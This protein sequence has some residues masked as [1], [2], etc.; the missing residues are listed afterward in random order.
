MSFLGHLFRRTKKAASSSDGEQ[1]VLLHL[2]GS[3]LPDEV[4]PEYDLATLEDR[5]QA[6]LAGK[7]L[8]EYDGSEFGPGGTT[9]YLYGPDA[10]RLCALIQPILTAYPLCRNSRVVIR[11]GGPRAPQREIHVPA[12]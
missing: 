8:G 1:A 11:K 9:L 4:Y 7:G 10:E 6:E 12:D 5:I 3:S 2:D